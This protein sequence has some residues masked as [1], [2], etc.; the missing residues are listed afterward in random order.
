MSGADVP[1]QQPRTLFTFNSREDLA[2]FAKGS[3][4][5]VGGT[6]T[7]HLD[8]DEQNLDPDGLP[9]AKFFG[10]LSLDV[11]KEFKGGVRPGYAAFRSKVRLIL[12]YILPL[13]DWLT[14]GAI[15]KQR[16]PTLFGELKEDLSFHQLLAL[17]VRYAGH[18]RLANSWFV[19]LQSEGYVQQDLWQHRLYFNRT[20]GGWE[21][22]FVSVVST[23]TRKHDRS[24]ADLLIPHAAAAQK[25]RSD[26]LWRDRGDA[27]TAGPLPN[28]HG[29]HLSP[30]R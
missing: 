17:R 8:L 20:D 15:G 21:D 19:N 28:S 29:R 24:I 18:P 30:R 3:D 16:R 7:V 13:I 12:Y 4:S 25:L 1:D 22:I 11:K 9:A 5:D 10:N 14:S 23:F 2:S 26:K 27:S 6:S